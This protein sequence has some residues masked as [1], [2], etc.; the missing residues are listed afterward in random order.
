MN[1]PAHLILGAASFARA[2]KPGSVSAALTG[3]LA[4]DL[5]LY[6]L[7]GWHFAVLGTSAETVFGELYYSESWQSVFAIDNSVFVWGLVLAAGLFGRW[8]WLQVFGASALL[9]VCLDFPLHAGDGRPHFW[10]FSD[11]VF[12]SPVSY[13]DVRHFGGLV[14]S[15]EIVLCAVLTLV[16]VR[17]FRELPLR[18]LFVLLFACEVASSG[19]WM[20]VF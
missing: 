15:I 20:L 5:S 7:A 4:P 11:W 19:I 18:A 10:P 16:L 6:L 8:W 13:W 14:G 9:H 17:K 1:T 2:Q 3:S 12:D